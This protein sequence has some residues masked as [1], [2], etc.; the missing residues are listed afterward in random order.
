LKQKEFSGSFFLIKG[1]LPTGE[2]SLKI[3]II[4]R[5]K[6]GW[7]STQLRQSLKR[8]NIMPVCFSFRQLLA[9]VN[10]RPY[11]S[12]EKVDIIKDLSALI[13]RPIGRGSLE[14]VVFRMDVL[15]RLSRLG[16]VVINPATSIERSVDKYHTLTILEEHGIPVPRT[17]VTED[18]KEAL[19]AFTKLGGDVVM[20]PLFG[21][22]G[23]GTTR[24][25]DLDVATRIFK[26]VSFYHG[27]IY[28][29]EFIPHAFP[30]GFWDIRAFVVGDHSVAAMRRTAKNWKTNVSQGAQPVS[31]NLNNELESLAVKTTKTIGCE[32]AGVDVIEGPKGPVIIELNSQPG[33]RGLQSVTKRVI[34]DEIIHHMLSTL[35]L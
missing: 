13:I 8:H 33:W 16:M 35:K 31:L 25:T 1:E 24:I 17:A 29:Q 26:T 19:R 21:S 12:A 34:A 5:D 7:C 14:E 11:A 20:K 23:M 28:I 32:L 4:T 9:Q 27:V 18:P 3:G 22:R 30:N 2:T 15:H 10:H 6:K